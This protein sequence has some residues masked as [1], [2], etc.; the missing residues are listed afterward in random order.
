MRAGVTP[1]QYGPRY[2]HDLTTLVNAKRALINEP[3]RRD[4]STTTTA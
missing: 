3:L 2:R 4:T 1:T